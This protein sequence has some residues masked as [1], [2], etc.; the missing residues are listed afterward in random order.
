[1]RVKAVSAKSIIAFCL[2]FAVFS[3]TYTK[4]QEV[5][6]KEAIQN[7]VATVCSKGSV[8][9]T[10]EQKLLMADW[11]RVNGEAVKNVHPSEFKGEGPAMA[12]PKVPYTW[13]DIRF[14]ESKN[15]LYMFMMDVPQDDMKIKELCTRV[16]GRIIGK[17][18]LLGSDE[19]MSWEMEAHEL[20]LEKPRI[21]PKDG[22]TVFKIT[23]TDYYKELPADKS[24][25]IL[26]P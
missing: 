6:V 8:T 9:L 4:A 13:R 18:K 26:N 22:V 16:G 2:G 1:M 7:L 24:I 17:V 20:S 12:N 11:L 14:A 10:A 5:S 25:K 23:W 19:R 3:S 15:A 21:L